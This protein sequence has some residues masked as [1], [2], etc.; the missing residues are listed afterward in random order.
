MMR[1]LFMSVFLLCCIHISSAAAADW[2]DLFDGKTL[3]GWT[4]ESGTAKYE[5]ENGV[6]VGSTV[7]GAANSFLCTVKEYGDFILEF[8]VLDDTGV[9]Q[10]TITVKVGEVYAI[11]DGVFQAGFTG[12]ITEI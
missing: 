10:N 1:T 12:T 4:V 6:I 11:I 8:D 2:V 9:D 5:V 7:K 3:N